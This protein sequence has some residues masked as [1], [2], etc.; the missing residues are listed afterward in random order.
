MAITATYVFSFRVGHELVN[1]QFYIHGK[2]FDHVLL[3]YSAIYYSLVDVMIFVCYLPHYFLKLQWMRLCR[4]LLRHCL[5]HVSSCKTFR[6]LLIRMF[7]DD[8]VLFIMDETFWASLFFNVG[9]ELFGGLFFTLPFEG[10]TFAAQ[11]QHT[12]YTYH[13]WGEG[14]HGVSYNAYNVQIFNPPSF[15]ELEVEGY[16]QELPCWEVAHF[17]W[18]IAWGWRIH[19][20]KNFSQKFSVSMPWEKIL[21]SILAVA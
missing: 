7:Y 5:Y 13:M 12:L 11:D 18:M 21:I 10:N 15:L 20:G 8:H 19:L 1:H 3:T 9:G 14:W 17:I 16:F 6:K 4:V 2:V